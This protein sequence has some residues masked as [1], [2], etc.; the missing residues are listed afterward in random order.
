MKYALVLMVLVSSTAFADVYVIAKKD[1][2]IY[3]MSEKN[4]TVVPADCSLTVL[5]GKTLETLG[6]TQA[7]DLYDFK[8]E[9]FKLNAKRVSDRDNAEKQ[10]ALAE[11]AEA[12][13][14]SSAVAKLAAL[15][16]TADEIAAL[17]GKK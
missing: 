15:G 14:K 5:R 2:T 9:S 13:Q 10:A 8:G 4:D 6:M 3:T 1:G 11:T 12:A 7:P 16:L 17:T